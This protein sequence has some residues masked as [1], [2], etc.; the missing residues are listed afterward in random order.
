MRRAISPAIC[1]K[2]T[3]VPSPSTVTTFCSFC[4]EHSSRLATWKAP[5]WYCTSAMVPA[6]GVRFT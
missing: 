3:R 6:M 4:V 2:T 5:S 1:L